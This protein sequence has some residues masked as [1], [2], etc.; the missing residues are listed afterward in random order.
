IIHV[1]VWKKG[2]DRTIYN[3]VYQDGHEGAALMKR[4]YVDGSTRD[5]DYDLTSGT[6]NSRVLYFTA[7]PN[8]EAEVLNVLLRPRPHLKKLRLEVDLSELAIKGRS[9]KGNTLTKHLI[10]K[11]TQREVLGSTLGARKLWYNEIVNR[12]NDEERGTL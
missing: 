2:D 1:A 5:K 7:N 3:M 4:F 8:G 12:L 10:S 11:I 6:K 9:S